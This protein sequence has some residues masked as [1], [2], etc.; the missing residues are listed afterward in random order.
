[1]PFMYSEGK[2]WPQSGS[3][4]HF[5][6]LVSRSRSV[7][8]NAILSMPHSIVLMMEGMLDARRRLT[9]VLM[10]RV[11]SGCQFYWEQRTRKGRITSRLIKQHSKQKVMMSASC[12]ALVY[13]KRLMLASRLLSV[14]WG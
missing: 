12:G 1:M 11:N 3:C 8:D 2:K 5:R 10:L 14:F 9:V 13:K 6:R 4:S 7:K